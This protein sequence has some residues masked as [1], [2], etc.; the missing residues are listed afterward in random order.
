MTWGVACYCCL[1]QDEAIQQEAMEEVLRAR[2]E[3]RRAMQRALAEEEA[4]L[5]QL[6]EKRRVWLEELKARAEEARQVSSLVA[7]AGRGC[8]SLCVSHCEQLHREEREGERE[9]DKMLMAALTS[10]EENL[11]AEEKRLTE[12]AR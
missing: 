7:R 2:R 11:T 10:R 3:A 8:H 6:R 5:R 4:L 12:E 9:R 1:T